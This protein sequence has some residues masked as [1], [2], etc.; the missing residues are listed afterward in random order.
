MKKIMIGLFALL[1]ASACGLA[2][3]E[4]VML[5]PSDVVKISVYANP[6]LALETRITQAGTITFPL[7]GQVTVGGMTVS[8]AETKLAGLLAAGGFVRKAQVNILVTTQQSQLVSV[9]GQVTKPGRYPVDGKPGLIDVLALAGGVLPDGGD[10]VYL[11]RKR[12][13]V[14]TKEVVD[15]PEVMRSGDLNQNLD[16]ITG[17]VVYVERAP[18][19]YIYGE[20]QKPGAYRL[21]RNMTVQQVLSVGGGLTPRGTERGMRI[22]HRD[23][24]GNVTERAAK[25]EDV[26]QIDDVITVK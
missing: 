22:K 6:D 7:L 26:V 21:E 1:I 15:L 19:F 10:V 2:N 18:R 13:G 14:K 8:A 4:D 24:A 11:I 9:L 23:S 17:D 25:Q 12:D 3:A 20:V 5:G 16:L